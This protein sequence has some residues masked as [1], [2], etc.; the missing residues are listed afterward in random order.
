[1]QVCSICEVHEED[2]VNDC[3]VDCKSIKVRLLS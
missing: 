3:W 1:V 2:C